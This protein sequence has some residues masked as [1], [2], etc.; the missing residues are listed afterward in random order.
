MQIAD[1][2]NIFVENLLPIFL[3][4][5]A[6]F[7]F[8]RIMRPDIKTASRLA[9]HVFSP[10]LIFHTLVRVGVAGS[11]LRQLALFTFG[12]AAAMIALAYLAGKALCAIAGCWPR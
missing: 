7:A 2:F 5:G 3:T 1:I 12:I 4:A 6:G 11:E 10:C 9:F 8:G